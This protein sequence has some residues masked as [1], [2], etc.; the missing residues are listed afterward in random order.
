M[1]VPTVYAEAILKHVKT[2]KDLLALEHIQLKNFG[3]PWGLASHVKDGV[4]QLRASVGGVFAPAFVESRPY[5]WPFNGNL[6]VDNTALIVIDM[7]KVRQSRIALCW[8]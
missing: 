5:L 4:D 2:G 3:V 1:R 6:T 8:G 7:Q